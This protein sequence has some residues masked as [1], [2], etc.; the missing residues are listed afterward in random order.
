MRYLD[1]KEG[2]KVKEYR[3]NQQSNIVT[4]QACFGMH[5]RKKRLK[6]RVVEIYKIV[7]KKRERIV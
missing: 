3:S 5:C 7:N 2:G 6:A 1:F 4:A